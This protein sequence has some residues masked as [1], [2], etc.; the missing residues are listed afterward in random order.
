MCVSREMRGSPIQNDADAGLVTAVHKL[1]EFRRSAKAAGGGE[2]AERLVAPRAVV[3][4]LH[5]GQQLD[6]R[7]A[8]IFDVGNQLVAEFSIA[9]PAIMI[10]RDPPP[11]TEMDFVDGNSRLE[12]VSLRAA[13]EPI[14]VLPF[15]VIE[16]G[17]D[18]AGVWAKLGAE[19]VGIGFEREN[20]AVW[21]DDLILVDGAF[22][23]F[24]NEDFPQAGRAT[25][26]HRMDAAVPAVEISP[27]AD[28]L[29]AGGPNGEVNAPDAFD[30][31]HISAE[32][33]VSVVVPPFAHQI[34]IKLAEYD[35]KGIGVEDLEGIAGVC[36]SLNLVT[37]CGRRSGLLRRPCGLEKAFGAEFQRVRD[38]CRGQRSA[39][40]RGRSQRDAGFRH[41]R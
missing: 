8:E 28:A 15:M 34:Q 41:P 26:A 23:E 22:V 3:G 29:S 14:G 1:H 27:Y 25:S 24:G 33:F 11:R 9:K 20:V 30:G 32:F 7:V 38:F 19:G 13:R 36:A 5:D 31:N 37:A 39:F 12:P 21:A 40:Y 16:V 6:M 35:W 17:N 2:V 4:M 10:L 18:R